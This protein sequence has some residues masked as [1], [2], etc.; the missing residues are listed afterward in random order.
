MAEKNN[1][2]RKTV[3]VR[4]STWFKVLQLAN[5]RTYPIPAEQ[6][7]GQIIEDYFEKKGADIEKN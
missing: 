3:K 5:N 1:V 6:Q 7:A 4:E 2:I